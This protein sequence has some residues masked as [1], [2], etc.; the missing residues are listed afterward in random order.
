MFN[1]EYFWRKMIEEGLISVEVVTNFSYRL[2]YNLCMYV[3]MHK[4]TKR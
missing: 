1:Y 2:F 3:F 4:I